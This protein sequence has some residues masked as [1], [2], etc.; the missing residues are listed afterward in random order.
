MVGRI[1]TRVRVPSARIS[2]VIVMGRICGL[3][4]GIGAQ[5][6]IPGGISGIV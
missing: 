2:G 1:A 3:M 5:G 4:V 6:G